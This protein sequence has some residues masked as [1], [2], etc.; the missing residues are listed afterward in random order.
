MRC[1]SFALV[2]LV[3]GAALADPNVTKIED[4]PPPARDGAAGVRD[5]TFLPET[6]SARIG[7]QRVMGYAL[8]GYDTTAG[9]GAL[10]QSV[11]EG[12]LYNRVALRVGVD[13]APTSQLFSPSVGLRVGILRQ[14]RYGVDFGMAAFYKNEGFTEA[15]GEFEML[16]MLARRW[17]RLALFANLA[18]GQGIDP[19]ERDGELR[20]GL[21]YQLHERV[22]LGLDTRARFDLG[23]ETPQRQMARLE[24]DFDLI[25]G[26]VAA[27][28]V[29]H[30]V[31]LAQA[32]GRV[33]VVAEQ[34]RGG[35][36]AMGG[37]GTM[38]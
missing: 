21:M 29:G 25:A 26:P 1:L 17:N 10:F 13:Y 24:S 18:Y 8:G 12:A 38:F 20:V 5:G 37:V 7:D 15:K 16:V 3:S 27:V 6:L 33:V 14:E 22:Q 2:A 31:F 34:A 35:F 32:G 36:A 23:E 19:G 28:T 9:Q 30:F 4:T 11:V